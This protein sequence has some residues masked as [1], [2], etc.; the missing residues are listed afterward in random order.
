MTADG[1]VAMDELADAGSP[2]ANVRVF[3]QLPA[4]LSNALVNYAAEGPTIAITSDVGATD[5]GPAVE[6]ADVAILARPGDIT[7]LDRA[8]S[9]IALDDILSPAEVATL[10]AGPLADLSWVGS[11]GAGSTGDGTSFVGAPIAATASSLLW[12]PAEAFAK[13]GYEPPA[14]WPDLERL[15]ERMIADGRTPWCLGLV[16]GEHDGANGADLIEDLVLDRLTTEWYDRWASGLFSFNHPL[17]V[18][19]YEQYHALI[20]LDGAIQGGPD[21]AVR[22]PAAWV[23]LEMGSDEL[24]ACWLIHASGDQRAQWAGAVREDLTPI[25]FPI[26]GEGSQQLRGRVYMLVVLR[27]R[28]EVRA[29]VRHLLGAEFAS[30]LVAH[31]LGSGLVPTVSLGTLVDRPAGERIP[32]SLVASAISAGEFRPDASDRMPRS[33]GTIAFPESALR[34]AEAPAG[35]AIASILREVDVIE[36]VRTAAPP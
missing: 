31:D 12:Y 4:D 27:D 30:L 29:L 13:A 10:A 23:A 2:G 24:P 5:P 33:L 32:A 16:G 18:G 14:T 20:H 25:K 8:G 21:A 17:V 3:S 9:L 26:G 35:S 28:P 36:Q 15:V 7:D 6:Q 1:P 22:T 11:R 19:A 34:V